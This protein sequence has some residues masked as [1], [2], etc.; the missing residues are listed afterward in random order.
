MVNRVALACLL[1]LSACAIPDP[2]MESRFE[3]I[4]LGTA[5]D[6]GLPH[7]GCEKSCCTA[8]RAS[9]RELY[10]TSLGIHDKNSGALL[11]IEATPAIEVQTALLQK[12][13]NVR[14]KQR[15]V[16]DGVLLTHAHIGHYLGLAQF[17][18]EVAGSKSVPVWLT[19]RFAGFLTAHGPWKQLIQ[20]EQLEL[21]VV[22]LNQLFEPLPGLRVEAIRVP[23]RDEFSDTVAFRIHGPN[24]SVLYVP[25][26]DHLRDPQLISR[27]FD[28]IDLAFVDGT[29]YDGRELPGPIM[30]EVPHPL[31][32]E[33][34]RDFEAAGIP[35]EIHFIHLNHTNP[36]LHD[37]KLRA[38][39]EARGFGIAK[40]GDIVAL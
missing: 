29:F 16:V 2:P 10:P 34:M 24:R 6:G 38:E 26:I 8:A 21:N 28:G 5:Q 27:L 23:H 3:L 25:D 33:S 18:T 7:F 9:G 37:A 31:I 15:Q 40:R 12:W 1:I 14:G 30:S 11:L 36:L 32:V 20:L 39:V 35:A 17:G 22:Q 4:V 13:A 19:E